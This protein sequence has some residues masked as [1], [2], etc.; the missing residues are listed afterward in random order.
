[1]FMPP[2]SLGIC[3]THR[4]RGAVILYVSSLP[5]YFWLLKQ[6][7]TNIPFSYAQLV[8]EESVRY[9]SAAHF[10]TSRPCVALLVFDSD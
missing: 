7:R 1:M 2:S 5:C 8:Q 4:P 6:Q 3:A 9:R 10:D